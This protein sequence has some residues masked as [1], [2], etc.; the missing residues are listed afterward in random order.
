MP[1]KQQEQ[2]DPVVLLQNSIPNIQDV[3][4]QDFA[5]PLN[6]AWLSSI[7]PVLIGPSNYQ[8]LTNMRYK[9]SGIGLEGVNGYHEF[10]ANALV[11]YTNINTGIH[12]K[13]FRDTNSYVI[14]HASTNE[15]AGRLY[16]S[17]STIDGGSG[18]GSFVDTQLFSDSESNL[19]PYL[20]KAPGG[21][22]VYC[23]EKETKVWAGTEF[24]ASTIYSLLDTEADPDDVITDSDSNEWG[25][26]IDETD[27]LT[28]SKTSDYFEISTAGRA[29]VL[30]FS[31]RKLNG[32][33]VY[34]VSGEENTNAANTTLEIDIWTGA[35]F[36]TAGTLTD[37]TSKLTTSGLISFAEGSP[38]LC[39]YQGLYLYAYLLRVAAS[40]E[41]STAQ[42]YQ[43]TYNA[44]I[45]NISNVWDGQYRSAI[46]VQKYTNSDKSYEDYTLHTRESSTVVTPVGLF[47][48][49]T[50][51]N[52]HII[53]MFEEQMAGVYVVM[54]GE[55]VN[56][57]NAKIANFQYWNGSAFVNLSVTDKTLNAN[58]VSSFSKTGLVYWNPPSNEVSTTLFSSTGYVYKIILDDTTSGTNPEDLVVDLVGGIPAI[59]D[60]DNFKFPA[61]FS[62]RLMLCGLVESD[63]GN[64]IDF[65]ASQTPDIFN[66]LDSSYGGIQSIYVGSSEEIKAAIQ[67]YNRFGS[68]I[69][70]VFIILKNNETWLMTGESPEDFRLYP[71]SF[72]M[73][74]PAPRT[75]TTAEVGFEV[76]ESIERNV[77]MWI[78]HQGPVMFDGAVVHP[79]EGIENYFDPDLYDSV[80][81][82]YIH[83]SYGW[84]DNIYQEWNVV[85]PTKQSTIVNK[86]LVYSV[87]Q[88]KWFEKNVESA[89]FPL[90]GIPSISPNGQQVIYGGSNNGKLYRLESGTSWN[91]VSITYIVK[92][93]DFF[94]SNNPWDITLLRRFKI[95]V[96]KVNIENSLLNIYFSL[97]TSSGASSG[98]GFEDVLLSITDSET[99][100][101]LFYDVTLSDTDSGEEGF[102]WVDGSSAYSVDLT[103]SENRL[104]DK[105]LNINEVIK[106]CSLT[107]ECQSNILP[108]GFDII[109]WG[110]QWQP[111]RKD[112]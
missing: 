73:G 40:A 108:K 45:Q 85:L 5:T 7:D 39:H 42:V 91:G 66:G 18:N 13:N 29:A 75:L 56:T 22:V 80:N 65:S 69:Y 67:L 103:D 83:K 101:Y 30:M 16:Y 19:D 88:K 72:N 109:M 2:Q 36:T 97:N 53:M 25:F 74:C 93:G 106:T 78:S 34:L 8:I 6:G 89:A 4:F 17:T 32:V 46:Q 98:Y 57:A 95:L 92:T 70:T 55:L 90:C 38:A 96:K 51:A 37:G 24:V 12:L 33:R 10:N 48:G 59:K 79:L 81:F 43:I 111:L 15:G 23:N 26:S 21:T 14:V 86:W 11:S 77:A 62:N 71:I 64:R 49:A 27:E 87:R 107:F 54:L 105:V 41:T 99:E 28:N 94:P 3:S 44:D 31:T 35:A 63:E 9:K 68:N 102:T 52:D 84:Y 61:L 50:T 60:V 58:S 1:E 82:D 20:S 112:M 100:G 110:Y 104:V 47:M 76:G